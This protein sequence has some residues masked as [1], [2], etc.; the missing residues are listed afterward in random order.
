MEGERQPADGPQPVFRDRL[1]AVGGGVLADAVR[2][3]PVGAARRILARAAWV[4]DLAALV[5]LQPD[6]PEGW[7]AVSRDG[8]AVAGPIAIALGRA[9]GPLER[10]AQLERLETELGVAEA[11]VAE[12]EREAVAASA[13]ATD[14]RTA[15]EAARHE[16]STAVARRRTVEDDERASGRAAERLARESAWHVAL[17]ERAEAETARLHE[18][19]AGLERAAAERTEAADAAAQGGP[20]DPSAL[21]TWE[22]RAAELRSRRD[23]LAVSLRTSDGARREAEAIVARAVAA[24]TYDQERIARS[25][26]DERALAAREAELGAERERLAVDAA[27][28]G[29]REAAARTALDEL[30][31]ADAVDRERSLAAEAAATAARDRLRAADERIRTAEVADLEMRL[32]LD[33]IREQVLVELAGIGAVGT[34]ALRAAALDLPDDLTTAGGDGTDDLAA[35][36]ELADG[37]DLEAILPFVLPAWEAAPP[38]SIRR[39]PGGSPLS[40]ADSTSSARST[41]WPS[42]NTPS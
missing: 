22:M 5:E 15:L 21:A 14:A 9:E 36:D 37:Q 38:R 30:R 4:P 25:E 11:E 34:R 19:L 39:R 20:D 33:A 26:V 24:A 17:A 12:L 3:D 13:T 1:A 35:D 2:R 6:L 42:R 10:R 18:A 16:E 28:A 23:R 7:I 32:G 8:G 40:D 41:R 29:A 31:S 27:A